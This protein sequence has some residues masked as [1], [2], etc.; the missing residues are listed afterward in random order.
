[1]ILHTSKQF[2]IF[3]SKNRQKYVF[4]LAIC[5][6]LSLMHVFVHSFLYLISLYFLH[7][8]CIYCLFLYLW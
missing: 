5:F 1:M 7:L 2:V 6:E 3:V 4:D 8:L